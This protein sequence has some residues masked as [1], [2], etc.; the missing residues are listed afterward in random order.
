MHFNC[1]FHADI[2]KVLNFIP[3]QKLLGDIVKT[4]NRTLTEMHFLSTSLNIEH[5]NI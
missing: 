4:V 1:L 5:L 3:S 2:E